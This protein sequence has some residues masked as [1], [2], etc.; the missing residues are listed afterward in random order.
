MKL[1]IN[2]NFCDLCFSKLQ[3]PYKPIN[4][5]RYMLTFQCQKC[6]LIQSIPQKKYKSNPPPSMSFDADRASIMYTKVLVLPKYIKLF[7]KFKINF[8]R[9]RH[10]L[11]IGSNRGDF[12][13]FIL[14][15]NKFVQ[16]SA[17]E[18]KKI[19]F[20][21]YKKKNRVEYFHSRYEKF[22]INKKFDF[23]YN[24]HTLEH[25]ASS[26][27]SLK[28][29]KLQLKKSGMIFLAVPNIN[30]KDQNFFE[31]IFIDPHTFHF[32]NN[33]MIKYFNLVG[34]K[35]LKKNIKGNELQYLL[36]RDDNS[37]NNVHKNKIK[38]YFDK[39]NSLSI[40]KKQIL[41]NREK[42]K[43]KTN[44]IKDL[45]KK[46]HKIVFWGAGRIFDGLVSMG[47]ID[48][49]NNIRLVDKILYKF[50]DKLHGFKLIKPSDLNFLEKKSILVVC[51]R[52]YKL[53]IIKEAKKFKFRKIIEVA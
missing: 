27:N 2:N 23:I 51:S 40:Y 48:P 31:E 34:L 28:K 17:L 21:K 39:K 24:V 4:T 3:N 18:S 30:P 26:L 36:I 41:L 37:K 49:A 35:I 44:E 5:K 8:S 14:E 45:I 32:T 33:V 52:E 29:M 50:F 15:K 42:L 11:D 20:D 47:G 12:T 43:I 22:N 19:L 13:K 16:V 9:M 53:E 46:G 7:K 1:S 6:L 25:F 10:V 38:C